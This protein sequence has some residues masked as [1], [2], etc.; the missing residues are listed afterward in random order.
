MLEC[1]SNPFNEFLRRRSRLPPTYQLQTR[2]EIRFGQLAVTYPTHTESDNSVSALYPTEARLRNLTY[3]S[4][5]YVDVTKTAYSVST[6]EQIG[7]PVTTQ[8]WVGNVPIMVQSAY[9]RLRDLSDK[10]K[11]KNGE[12]VFDQGGYFVINGSEKVVIA[13]ERQAYNRV[14]CFTKKPPSKISCVAEIRS[15]VGND[16]KPRSYMAAMMYRSGDEKSRAGGATHGGQIR[17]A[18]PLVQQDIPVVVFFRALGFQ[19]DR[20]VLTHVVYDV[21]D[22]ELVEAMRPSLE[23]SRPISTT[24]AAR[25]FIGTRAV[26]MQDVSR[27]GRVQYVTELLQKDFLPHVG[28]DNSAT[29][30]TRKCY[31]LGYVVHK[32]LLVSLGRADEDDRDHFANKRLDLA[33]PLIGSLFRLLFYNMTK[34][35]R[36]FLQ[37]QLDKGREPNVTLGIKHTT[38]TRGLRYSLAT[39]NWGV[40]GGQAEM[41]SGVSQVLNRLTYASSLSHLRR[42]NTPLGREGKQAKPR[43]LHNTQWGMICP[44]ETPEG[45]SIGEAASHSGLLQAG[46]S[47]GGKLWYALPTLTIVRVFVHAGLVKNLALMAYISKGSEAAPVLGVSCCIACAYPAA[48]TISRLEQFDGFSPRD[49]CID[50]PSEML[51]DWGVVHLEESRPE[52]L[53]FK[54]KVFL[55]GNWVGI[56][57]SADTGALVAQCRAHR[58]SDKIESEIS[59]SRDV[60]TQEVHIFTD[61]GRAC[62]PL[63]IVESEGGNAGN[64]MGGR[65]S[66]LVRKGHIVE[67]GALEANFGD[68]TRLVAR[69]EDPATLAPQLRRAL[70]LGRARFTWLLKKGVVEYIDTQVRARLAL[71]YAV[72]RWSC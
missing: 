7:E 58:R 51:D 28:V 66:L 13:Q 5:L 52:D 1:A 11:V 25:N 61:A 14:Y 67:L 44:C 31:Y 4:G 57:D 10:D 38:L 45:S 22:N 55:N 70:A 47:H 16:N 23:E 68:A 17:V 50:S 6:N 19:N 27:E 26:N 72:L 37:K 49:I 33:G 40:R 69:G 65:Q 63:F 21:G 35:M 46:L 53:P 24:E 15:Q 39:G 36:A 20:Q 8:E 48:A 56:V 60:Y 64:V 29:T 71:V 42:A 59:I 12:C 2:Y 30:R 41:K 32:L 34:G 3:E 43:Q 9:C 18:M 54:S 62:R